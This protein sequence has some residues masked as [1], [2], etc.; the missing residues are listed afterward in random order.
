MKR[1]D[2]LDFMGGIDNKYLDEAGEMRMNSVVD[3]AGRSKS[4]K[5]RSKIM[6]LKKFSIVAAALVLVAGIGVGI[7]MFTKPIKGEEAANEIVEKY[8]PDG[9]LIVPKGTPLTDENAIIVPEEKWDETGIPERIKAKG[10][11]GEITKIWKWNYETDDGY[12]TSYSVETLKV[13]D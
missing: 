2:M 8:T 10:D 7:V 11:G 4:I 13:F 1:E 5:R 9:E 6:S 3:A 12:E